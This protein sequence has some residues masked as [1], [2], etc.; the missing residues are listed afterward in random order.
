MSLKRFEVIDTAGGLLFGT[1][2][3]AKAE[4]FFDMFAV[5]GDYIWDNDNEVI[6]LAKVEKLIED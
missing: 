2:D 3:Q 5:V 1:D 6:H 4:E